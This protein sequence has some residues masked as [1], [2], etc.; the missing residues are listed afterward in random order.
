MKNYIPNCKKSPSTISLINEALTILE[1]VGVPFEKKTERSLERMALCF[2]AVA[3]VTNEWNHLK[4][5]KESIKVKTRNIIQFI[6]TH[7]EENISPGS[8]DDIRRKDLKL[9]VLANLVVNSG[10]VSGS[11]TNDPTRGYALHTSFHKLVSSFKTEKWEVN[12]IKFRKAHKSIGDEL[13]RNR[14]IKKLPVKLPNG[15][16]VLLSAGQHNKLQ[17]RI[18]EDFLPRFGAN[19]ELLYLGDTTNKSLIV[20]KEKLVKLNFFELSHDQLPDIVAFSEDKNW[21]YLIEAVHSSGTMSE[22]R[23]YELKKLLSQSSAELI[24]VTAFLTRNDFKKWILDIAWETEVWI[25]D[26]PDH[27]IHFNGHKF[28]GAY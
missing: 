3:G 13:S 10:E 12:L 14:E 23:V 22:T 7:F 21:L 20:S 11:A 19:A 1:S 15:V 8:Y 2:L 27:L 24:F 28:L 25:A 4:P 5:T 18:I 9:L 16:D 26:N 17:K 6:N